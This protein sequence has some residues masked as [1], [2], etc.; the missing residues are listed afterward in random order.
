[1]IVSHTAFLTSIYILHS[2]LRISHCRR[3]KSVVFVSLPFPTWKK[4]MLHGGWI[5][6]LVWGFFGFMEVFDSLGSKSLSG[7][8]NTRT[9]Y[10][11]R[12]V[13]FQ[14]GTATV[15]LRLVDL[16]SFL[17]WIGRFSFSGRLQACSSSFWPQ[18]QYKWYIIHH[19]NASNCTSLTTATLKPG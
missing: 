16:P 5:W 18:R 12:K 14:C 2:V 4:Q 3:L 1:M 11:I 6:G 8:S 9:I 15:S 19:R 10:F 13:L 7:W 17:L